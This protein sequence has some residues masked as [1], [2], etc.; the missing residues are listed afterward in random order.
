MFAI[1][2]SVASH[3]VLQLVGLIT[4]AR[5]RPVLHAHVDREHA[6]AGAFDTLDHLCLY[7]KASEQ[8]VEVRRSD[9]VRLAVLHCP[10]RRPEAWTL[11]ERLPAAH[12]E[13]VDDLDESKSV[14]LASRP[15]AV[16]LVLRR[17]ERLAALGPSSARRGRSRSRVS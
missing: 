16:A 9:H 15:D 12:V 4:V 1:S 5:G 8:P 6:A 14:A 10:Y 17:D 11:V 3:E 2:L 7:S 13:L